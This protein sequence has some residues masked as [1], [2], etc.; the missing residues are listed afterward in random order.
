M[1]GLKNLS[2][3]TMSSKI[4]NGEPLKSDKELQKTTYGVKFGG[5]MS[6]E[7][8][9]ETT[10][11]YLSKGWFSVGSVDGLGFISP[12]GEWLNYINT[13]TGDKFHFNRKWAQRLG[14]YVENKG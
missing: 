9:D 6:Q 11:N 8:I 14:F 13:E 2:G 7:K 10:H 3:K 5:K 1:N 12:C 4:E